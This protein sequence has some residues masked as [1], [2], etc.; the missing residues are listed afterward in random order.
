MAKRKPIV[1]LDGGRMGQLP[2]GD[3]LETPAQA[4]ILDL[5]SNAATIL[6]IGTPV[7]TGIGS[8]AGGVFAARANAIGTAKAIGL[9]A[10]A[11]LAPNTSGPILAA[12]PLTATVAQWN[13]VIIGASNGLNP[14]TDYFLDYSQPGKLLPTAPEPAREGDFLV[15]IGTALTQTILLVNIGEAIAL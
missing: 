1:L 13:A 14:G 10:V 6:P 8:G 15:K 12:G 2:S 3:T 5:V 4:L 11:Q 9:V 7:I